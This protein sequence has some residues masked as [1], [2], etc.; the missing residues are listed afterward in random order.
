M[1]GGLNE[2]AEGYK[3]RVIEKAMVTLAFRQMWSSTGRA[4]GTREP[5]VHR[6]MQK[7]RPTAAKCSWTRRAAEPAYL[8]RDK[9]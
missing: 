8:P 2:E 6:G 5:Y 4:E 9:P 7:I 1:A 3:Q